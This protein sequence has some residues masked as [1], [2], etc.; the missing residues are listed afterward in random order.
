MKTRIIVVRH[1][2]SEGNLNKEFHGQYNS[3]IT[4]FGI[5]QAQCTAKALE[6]VH[7]DK[8]FS[9]DIRRAFSTTSIIA[10]P[11]KLTVEKDAGL[12]ELY[13]GE[14]E[15]GKFDDLKTLYPDQYDQWYTNLADFTCPGGESIRFLQQRVND[16]IQ[17]I[18]KT[19][20]GKT[21][22]IGTHAT[23]IRVMGCI[24]HRIPLQDILTLNWV[25]NASYSTID[26]DCDSLEFELIN[27]AVCS[28]LEEKNLL[29]ELPKNI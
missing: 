20:P 29:T 5:T 28:H 27:Y 1:A 16:T 19:N 21:L 22:L 25:P 9:S 10:K 26:Y 3:D 7:F 24:W 15:K 6:N 2:Q 23:P 18:V 12:R 17:K 4:E 13:A 14:W 11:H 8:A